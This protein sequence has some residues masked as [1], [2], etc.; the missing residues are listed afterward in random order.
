MKYNLIKNKIDYI[1]SV[2]VILAIA[3]M[4]VFSIFL[5]ADKDSIVSIKYYNEVVYQMSLGKNEVYTMKKEKF[6]K[7]LDDLVI[8]VKDGKVR[9]VEEESPRHYCSILGYVDSIGTSIICAPNGVVI[10][11]EG[12]SNSDIDWVPGGAN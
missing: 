7:L 6:P 10:T 4:I 2:I 8:E 9:V 3:M 12:K 1:I 11:I 5:K